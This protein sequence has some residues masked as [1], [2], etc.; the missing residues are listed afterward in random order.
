VG[1]TGQAR[2]SACMI[3]DWAAQREKV[4]GPNVGTQAHSRMLFFFFYS[5]LFSEF[6]DSN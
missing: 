2:L 3:P 5:F 4:D 1:L 6:K